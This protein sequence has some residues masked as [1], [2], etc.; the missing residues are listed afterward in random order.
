MMLGGA[1][2]ILRG[3]LIVV[4]TLGL[5][6]QTAPPTVVEKPV[7]EKS[8][9][10]VFEG[11]VSEHKWSL[12]D[13][14]PNL[15]SDWS[16]YNYLVIEMK[17]ST[18]QRFSLWLHTTDGKRRLMFQP[19]GQGVWLR[20]SIPLQYFKGK[21]KQGMDLASTN[22]RRTNS[23]WM[24]VWGPFGELKNV[25]ALSV[26]M[27]YPL[28]KPSL[29]IRSVKL[30]QEDA[31][32]EFVEKLPVLDE[33]GQWAHA[34]WPRKIKSRDQL[35]KELAV[36]TQNL[37]SLPGSG[38]FD[39]CRYGGYK[40][41]QAKATGFF[42]VEQIDGKWWFVDPDGHLFL[43]TGANCIRGSGGG[44][45]GG[46]PNPPAD[47]NLVLKRMSA[48]GLNTIGNWSSLRATDD[49]NRK[50]YVVMFR[51]P[52]SNPS[53]LGMPDVYSE[54]F[55]KGIDQA[56][57]TQCAQYQSDPWLLGYFLGNEPPW[58][59]RE[60][61]LVDM[62][63]GGP[64]TATQR[65]LKEYLAQGD[66][67]KRRQEFIYGMFEKYLALM[68]GAIKKHDPN[69]LNLG[70]RFG[71]MPAAPIMQ[72]AKSFDVCSINV[73]EYEPTKQ[74]KRVYELT[75]RP[76]MIGEFHVGVPADGLGAGLVQTASQAERAKGYRYYLEQGAAL[77][78]FLGAHWFQ[79]TDE[80]VLGRMDG[81]NYNIGF[82]DVTDRPYAELIDAAKAT[83]RRL[84]DVHAGKV[85]PFAEKPKASQDGTPGSPWSNPE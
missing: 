43:S 62:F 74:L 41:T 64:D 69:H 31:G 7:A 39:Y 49:V 4:V 81:E 14:D 84:A 38:A 22:N 12:Q 79:W 30:A 32:S 27:E 10:A 65:K 76:V 24:Q 85:T 36:E 20:A 58:P 83:H 73:Y 35:Q 60:S 26:A 25:Q 13:L 70:I 16:A 82:V 1:M 53:Y 46:S 61:E 66:T 17:P 19:F 50:A 72:L 6:C 28:N 77:P 55:A 11:K 63:L 57:Q 18:P 21:D 54:E 75:G 47:P 68:S 33:F 52:R 48:W 44:Q 34:D 37:A 78:C 5:G 2:R 45:R 3:T 23:F 42:H 59:G 51:G 67:A 80:P 56:A 29:E 15:P 71:G 40:N 8:L 9:K